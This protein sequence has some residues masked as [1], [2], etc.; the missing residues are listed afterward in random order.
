MTRGVS[1]Q[2]SLARFSGVGS[3]ARAAF[4]ALEVVRRAERTRPPVVDSNSPKAVQAVIL[5]LELTNRCVDLELLLPVEADASTRAVLDHEAHHDAEHHDEDRYVLR[6]K[7]PNQ[8]KLAERV[9]HEADLHEKSCAIGAKPEEQLHRGV[10]RMGAEPGTVHRLAR[11]VDVDLR[12]DHHG[13]EPV[14]RDHRQQI[15][16]SSLPVR[17]TP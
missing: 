5:L 6:G 17:S 8:M 3:A 10:G 9:H 12:P 7:R 1:A 2:F 4:L 14:E 15:H 11:H 16:G 13:Q